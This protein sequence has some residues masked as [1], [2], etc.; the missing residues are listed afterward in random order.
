[1]KAAT[2]M[3][4]RLKGMVGL[5]SAGVWAG[6]FHAFGAWFLRHEAAR[7]GYTTS[8]VIYDEADQR[9]LIRRCIKD[10]NLNKNKVK[11]SVIAWLINIK[12]DTLKEVETLPESLEI[13][14]TPIINMYEDRKKAYSAFDFGDLLYKS[15]QIL[16]SYREVRDKYR[17]MFKD[18]L[19]DEYQDTNMAQHKM[20]MSIIGKDK[21]ICVVG[22]DDQSIYG[23][24]GADVGNILRFKEDFPEAEVVTLEQ[25]YRS[26]VDIL[27]A[28][29]NLI[30]NN[31][32]RAPKRLWSHNKGEGKGITLNEFADDRQ[33][34]AF[35]AHTIGRLIDK[36][37]NPSNIGVFYR[38]NAL[39]RVIE[40]AL[41]MEGISYAVYGGVRFYER[42]EIKDILAYLRLIANPKDEEALTRAINTP[43]RGIGNKTLA[44]LRSLA[45]DK[46]LSTIAIMDKAIGDGTI[47]G[48]PSRG[49]SAFLTILDKLRAY[50]LEQ[51]IGGL[52]SGVIDITGLQKMVASEIDGVDRI[53]NI[54]EFM[55]SASGET[56]LVG[57][58]EQKALIT[59]MD[60]PKGGDA[61]SVM[62]LHMSKGLEFDYVFI[63]GLE[64][65]L[66]PHSRSLDFGE[67]IEEER[68]LLYVGIT[69]AKKKA[70]LS[71]ARIRGLYGRETFQIPSSFIRE[72]EDL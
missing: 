70:F 9:A 40:E 25:N 24:R 13:D 44:K 14:P 42:R 4:Q 26:T 51:D 61:I 72:I 29:S 59:N 67:A 47:K 33:E 68:R 57:F 32:Y 8:F 71:W 19:V 50:A 64:E 5:R 30:S 18:I 65:G 48:A 1:N 22:D 41:V 63:L 62:T 20:L 15:C 16:S 53:T 3:K 7:I 12:R 39:S 35:M 43:P 69:R 27:D 21:N 45:R 60:I 6:T 66:L 11:D 54:K 49:I 56:D 46:G 36:G 23:W 55:A 2:E 58:L 31:R 10:L 28:A 38:I 52:I 37:V 17:S 34:A